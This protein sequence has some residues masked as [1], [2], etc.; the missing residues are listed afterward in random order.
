MI[1]A[2]AL[3][4]AAARSGDACAL[5]SAAEIRRVQGEEPKEAKGS[6][7]RLS[8]SGPSTVVMTTRLLRAGV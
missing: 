8:I 7:P 4:A 5:L 1:A 2:L 3:V 6:Q